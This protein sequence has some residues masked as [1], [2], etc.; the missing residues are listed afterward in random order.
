MLDKTSLKNKLTNKK[1]LKDKAYVD[2]KWV[3]AA[4]E[5]TFEIY[6]PSTHDLIIRV[7]DMSRKDAQKA[8]DAAYR[9]FPMWSSKIAKE[10]ADILSKFHN[11]IMENIDDLANILTAEMGKPLA[12]AKGEIAYGAS[13][14][15][16]FAEEAKRING[17]TI[18][19][20]QADK[21]ILVLKQPVGVVASITP[22]NFPNAMITRKIG[23]ALAAGCCFV[24][25]AAEDTPLSALA[26]CQLAEEAGIPPGVLSI[27]T[28]NDPSQIGEEFCVN[29]K[30]RKLTFTGSTSVGKILLRQG[31]DQVLKMSMELG[32]NAPFIV[33]DDADID[34]AVEG[35][36]VSK[37]RNNGQTCICAN[38]FYIQDRV[39]EEFAQK[40]T[41]KVKNMTVGDGFETESVLGP[42]KI[43]SKSIIILF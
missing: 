30:V 29:P 36:I 31:A 34:E 16:W 41:E 37:Y 2:G 28:S 3:S 14:I 32:G 20:H 12:E 1:L 39:Y 35:A 26:L 19:S 38:R 43:F 42:L 13:F 33:F 24:G 40:L 23:P 6:N 9:A 5:K 11:L 4:S 8:I 18:P 27:I 22:W 17:E 7:P 21:R 10:R 25:K 15:Q